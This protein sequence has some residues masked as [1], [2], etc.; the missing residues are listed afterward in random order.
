MQ[1][2]YSYVIICSL[3]FFNNITVFADAP[4][5]Y[6]L[7]FQDPATPIMEGIIHFHHDLFT[8]LIFIGFFVCYL[9]IAFFIKFYNKNNNLP[10]NLKINH[11]LEI[12]WTLVPAAILVVIAIP[13]FALL[14]AMDELIE[15]AVTIKVIGHQW[16]W[17]YEYNDRDTK[18]DFESHMVADEDL[19]AGRFRL[20][21]VNNRVFVPKKT[22]IQFLITSQDVLHS[23]AIPSLGIKMDA[24]PGRLNGISTFIKRKGVFYGQCSEICGVNHAFMPIVVQ[25]L[26]VEDYVTWVDN[27]GGD[28]NEN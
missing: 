5:H 3:F 14:Y 24:C 23:W 16:F 26:D 4:K 27:G 11:I 17:S 7:S 9:F 2:L 6:Q 20:L 1:L 19:I 15:C 8:I 10:L 18:L 21:E 13:S 22:F 25:A 28:F 12:V